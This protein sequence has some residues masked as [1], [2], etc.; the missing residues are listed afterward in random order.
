MV[1]MRVLIKRVP[2]GKITFQET[3]NMAIITINRPLSRNSLTSAMWTELARLANAA[4]LNPKN[5]VVILKGGPGHFSAGSDIKEFSR[6]SVDEANE[7]FDKMEEAISAFENLSLPVICVIDGPALGAGFVLSLA[8]DIRIGSKNTKMGIPVGRL[9]I[10]LGPG[11]VQ[12]IVR[13]I[14]PSRTKE[15]VYT[16]KIY[17]YH[18]AKQLGLLN[19]LVENRDELNDV[20]F[21]MAQVIAGQS[22]ASLASVKKAVSLSDQQPKTRWKY[23]DNPVDFKEGCLSFVEKRKPNFR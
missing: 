16:G 18:D 6:M 14:G 17:D 4:E 5:K 20:C 12:R 2:D 11:F 15:L 13:L 10:T 22:P 9:G 8:C 7:A 19:I 21:K 3:S 23:V 1:D